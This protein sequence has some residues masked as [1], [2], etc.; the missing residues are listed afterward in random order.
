LTHPDISLENSIVD[1][2]DEYYM[3]GR[4]H[5]MLDGSQRALRII[6]E[7][8]DPEVAI[9]LLDFIL[10]YNASMDPVGE[11]IDA[12]QEAGKYAEKQGR[13]LEFVASVCG[14]KEDLQDLVMQIQMLKK[15]GVVVFESNAT[16]VQYCAR[17]L[18]EVNHA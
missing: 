6:R 14:T 7:A 18:N 2:G 9:I 3:V 15:S 17:L 16:A 5:P 8:H 12:I 13:H 4:P 1:M 10:G 11:L